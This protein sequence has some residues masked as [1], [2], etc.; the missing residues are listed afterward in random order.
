MAGKEALDPEV[1]Q[2][3]KLVRSRPPA[4]LLSIEE[5]RHDIDSIK[6]HYP[7]EPVKK[8]E[9]IAITGPAGKIRVRLYTP[10]G[11]GPFQPV[12]FYHGGGW[13]IGSLDSHEG[14]CTALTNRSGA[15]VFSIDYRLAP[16]NPFP[17]A[18]E[19]S[20]AALKYVS[21]NALSLDIDSDKL[22]VV[23]DSSGGNL[24]AVVSIKAK[25][26]NGPKIVL[27][28]LIYPATNMKDLDTPSYK[29]FGEGY[30]LD[31]GMIMKF[32]DCYVPDKSN[33]ADPRISPALSKDLKGLPPAL[34]IAAEC[35]PL[36]DDGKRFAEKLKT[37]GVPVKYSLYKGVI[38]GF[39]S[40]TTF[41]A[42]Q[43]AIKEIA[44]AISSCP[45][46]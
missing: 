17:A 30:D 28:V 21:A 46:S 38:H 7:P 40:F 12:V 3:L 2:Y 19:D 31:K 37:A 29:R 34:F 43:K 41:H 20:Y 44:D 25:E 11:K 42:A 14:V 23:G 13:S 4:H 27:Q 6:K 33:L 16:E 24:A 5:L 15:K 32:L 1:K 26:E 35:D 39:V 36:K 8:I 22:V 10:D 45:R 18:V 9:E